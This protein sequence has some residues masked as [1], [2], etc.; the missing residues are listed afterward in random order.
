MAELTAEGRERIEQA[1]ARIPHA[2]RY[3]TEPHQGCDCY[4]CNTPSVWT[5][6]YQNDMAAGSEA[7]AY[8]EA[9]VDGE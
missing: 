1:I 9:V 4:W 3:Y 2:P 7:I 6:Q 8:T 5:K